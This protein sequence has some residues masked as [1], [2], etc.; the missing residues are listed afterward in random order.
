MRMNAQNGWFPRSK[1]GDRFLEGS[2][3]ASGKGKSSGKSGGKS[4]GKSS[5]KS[6]SKGV[7]GSGFNGMGHHGPQTHIA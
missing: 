4:S 7:E 2:P 5:G 6:G 1:K 3:N